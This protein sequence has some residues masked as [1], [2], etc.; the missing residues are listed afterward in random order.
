MFIWVW[1]S[2]WR[3]AMEHCIPC[4]LPRCLLPLKLDLV[5]QV[6]SASGWF[7]LLQLNLRFQA[8]DVSHMADWHLLSKGPAMLTTIELGPDNT[9]I[10]QHDGWKGCCWAVLHQ[11]RFTRSRI[12]NRQF[13]N[14]PIKL[15]LGVTWDLCPL[16]SRNPAARFCG[17]KCHGW[18]KTISV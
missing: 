18:Q 17:S 11:A 14:E 7:F 3:S 10:N 6:V 9:G 13:S 4:H 5:I 1:K 8:D 15:C 12:N 2:F 16:L